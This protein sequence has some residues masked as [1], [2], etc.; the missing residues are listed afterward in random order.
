[1]NAAMV[2]FGV[3]LSTGLLMACGSSSNDKHGAS[4][5]GGAD[6]ALA[7]DGAQGCTALGAPGCGKGK[8]CCLSSLSGTC[9]DLNACSS[10]VQFECQSRSSCAVGE[11]CCASI[12]L[13]Q[14]IDWSAVSPEGG[15]VAL[16]V[17][18]TSFCSSS[19][20]RPRFSLCTTGADCADGAACA[21]LPEGNPI[22]L[23]LGAEALTV[24]API[25]GGTSPNV[26]G[27]SD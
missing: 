13:D 17:T 10:S 4:N 22:L 27:A 7:R 5:D 25:D 14:A 18:S 12:P 3:S 23:V 24:C 6:T 2:W 1:M 26:D 11:V 8:T 20:A 19:C 9:E 16:G 21:M 15:L